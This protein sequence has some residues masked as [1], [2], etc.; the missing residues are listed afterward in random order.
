M[1]IPPV[2]RNGY[3]KSTPT[4][5]TGQLQL[6]KY[7]NFKKIISSTAHLPTDRPKRRSRHFSLHIFPTTCHTFLLIIPMQYIFPQSVCVCLC[8]YFRY[9]CVCAFLSAFV[10]AFLSARLTLGRDSLSWRYNEVVMINSPG[11]GTGTVRVGREKG[12]SED[13]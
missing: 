13:G 2:V 11:T 12:L 4:T 8:I 3:G 5:T 9:V 6:P 1:A 10:F 7:N